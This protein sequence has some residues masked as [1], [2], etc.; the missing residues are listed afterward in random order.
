MYFLLQRQ[1]TKWEMLRP[2]TKLNP[3]IILSFSTPHRLHSL[4]SLIINKNPCLLPTNKVC[5]PIALGC[6]CIK[7]RFPSH[8]NHSQG[9]DLHLKTFYIGA[10]IS[11]MANCCK[12]IPKDA[13]SMIS[14]HYIA[15]SRIFKLLHILRAKLLPHIFCGICLM[16]RSVWHYQR[17]WTKIIPSKSSVISRDICLKDSYSNKA[18]DSLI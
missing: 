1:A 7:E 11:R 3:L 2:L 15:A 12:C 14:Y 13:R 8:C 16:L 6:T 4:V 18:H 10:F 9:H 5:Q 17:N